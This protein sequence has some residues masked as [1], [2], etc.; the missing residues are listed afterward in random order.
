MTGYALTGITREHA[1]FFLH[2]IGANGK[3]T[4]LETISGI[5]GN[6]HTSAP[7]EVFMASHTDRHPTELAGLRGAR[8]V[9]AVETEE[10]RRWAESRI[11]ALT[12]GD[13]ISARFVRQ[14][15]FEFRPEFKLL[16]CGNHKPSLRSVD[17]AMRRRLHMLPFTVTIPPEERDDQLGEKLKAEWGGILEWMIEGVVEWGR[18]GLQPPEIVREATETYLITEDTIATWIEERCNTGPHF[19]AGS[20]DLYR[21]WKAWCDVTG[22]FA[23]TQKRFSQGLEDRGFEKTRLIGGR[24]AFRG[25]GLA[26]INDDE[27]EARD[28]T[29][30]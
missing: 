17:E 21:A 19:V 3:S 7:M 1:L 12:G 20:T 24:Q 18:T 28:S 27:S 13:T 25:I 4:F 23:G 15:Y 29:A 16:I 26:T 10:G 11:K 22:E 2:G 6:Y 14:D 9:T 8:L 5:A 30:P